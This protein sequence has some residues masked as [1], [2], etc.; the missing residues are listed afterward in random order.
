MAPQ[1]GPARGILLMMAA[2]TVFTLM[3]AFVKAAERVP[4]G[5][6]MFFRSALAV[7]VVFAWL[8]AT[9]GLKGG[10]RTTSYRG[11]A[12]RGIAGATA[13]GLG[14]AGLK[15]LPLP[16]VTALRFITPV[17]IVVLAALMLGERFRLVRLGAVVMGLVGV[18]IITLPR[19]TAGFGTAEALGAVLTLGSAAMAA[20]AQIFVKSMSGR[21]STAAIVFYFSMTAAVLSLLTLPFGWVWPRG[22]D[23]IW[24]IGCGLL[25][26]VG[27]ILLTASYR[28]ADAGVL[29]PFTYV[30][31]LWAV[32]I[33]YV[34]FGEVPTWT[35]LGGAA[36]IISAG[37]VIVWRE[38]QLGRET[39]AER[40][41]V[42]KGYQ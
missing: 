20:L 17:I 2:M 5:E 8:W 19:F 15:F 23:W 11:H 12:F 1:P 31:M 29:A 3:S 24:L 13:M 37:I 28:H 39:T 22:L 32:V 34:W 6:T 26:G 16:E 21:E 25:G 33:G 10:V 38:R 14:F 30:T 42:A 18:T 35:M 27:Q 9:G 7:P 4:A 36:L 41:V 40:K